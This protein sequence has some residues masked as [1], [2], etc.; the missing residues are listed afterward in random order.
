MRY[1]NEVMIQAPRGEE[2]ELQLLQAVYAAPERDEPRLVYA[3]WL[4]ERGDARAELITLQCERARCGTRE[5]LRERSLLRRCEQ[6]WLGPLAGAVA[7]RGVRFERGFAASGT[8]RNRAGEPAEISRS[9][10]WSTFVELD[11]SG[12]VFEPGP[13]PLLLSPSAK[14][15][16]GVYGLSCFD[17]RLLLARGE[18]MGWQTLGGV[19]YARCADVLAD[20][21][22]LPEVM[23]QL[24]TLVLTDLGVVSQTQGRALL[25]SATGRQLHT[26]VLPGR[27]WLAEQLR[28]LTAHA[29]PAL[30]RLELACSEASGW[31][32]TY[33]RKRGGDWAAE[34]HVNRAD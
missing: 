31:H 9:A 27:P 21:C 22:R 30:Q 25:D 8:Y 10:A 7:L 11:V 13:L 17:L 2:Q 3:D 18:A 6:R 15:L 29:P 4:A 12:A 26:L 14:R 5:G 20:L 19:R 28:T 1:H 32:L 33:H 24:N 34:P 16:R 23:P